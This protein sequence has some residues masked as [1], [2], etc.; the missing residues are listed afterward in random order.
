MDSS[1]PP[2]PPETPG[3]KY[4]QTPYTGSTRPE[5]AALSWTP[6]TA[7]DGHSYGLRGDFTAPGPGAAGFGA[8]GPGAAGP[9]AAG[10]GWPRF[11]PP[12]GFDPSFP[13]P[14][15]GCPP[16]GLFPGMAPSAPVNAYSGA[17]A[18]QTFPQQ[19]RAGTPTPRYDRESVSVCSHQP[20]EELRE[21]GDLL[22]GP[23]G[24]LPRKDGDHSTGPEDETAVQR[25][26]D[27]QWV[28]RFLQ[29]RGK[30]SR[31]P[32]GR[33]RA[34]VPALRDA[35]YGAA[36]LVSRLE[37]LCES[38]KVQLDD[39]TG[40]TD[41]YRTALRLK[42]ELQDT[43]DLLRDAQA[44]DRLTATV[45]RVARSRTR[46][47]RA[48]TQLQMEQ[49]EAEERRVEKEAAIDGWRMK[50]IQQ[51]E[52]KKKER[53]LKL[54]ADSVLCE[55]RKKQTDVRRMTDVLRALEKLRRLRKEAASR[56]G[57][58]TEPECDEAFVSSVDGLRKVMK[59]RT[60]VYA[61]EEKALLVMLE[62]EQEEERRREQ[63]RRGRRERERQLQRRR[64]LDS[65]LFGDDSS[66]DRVLQP[67]TEFYN[68][69]Q[70][71]LH[72]LI[73]IRRE[74]DVFVVA[75]DHPDGSSVPQSWILPD[76]PSDQVWASV[77]QTVESE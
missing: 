58:L 19:F 17:G 59:R 29:N 25:R 56:K 21:G 45:A 60:E 5:H 42:T 2:A 61:V 41:S 1:Y 14:P 22:G 62:G 35:L 52:E 76:P 77:L 23:Q 57:I 54:V 34:S 12:H 6:S 47:L 13:P 10:F 48:R 75:A 63:E 64:R 39:D 67:F 32:Q 70:H 24:P 72:A 50:R 55:V 68:Q 38:L 27:A 43:A 8:A 15:F 11:D 9:G 31:S 4:V 73:Q 69:A 36:Q 26:H 49:E 33:P 46:R 51:V 53:E 28:R 65:L 18:F 66:A 40:W 7:Y 71:S 20:F 16:P 74:W 30:T 3:Y 37:E 44:L